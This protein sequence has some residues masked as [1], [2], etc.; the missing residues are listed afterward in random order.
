[1][2]TVTGYKVRENSEGKSFVVLE[3]SS[4]LQLVQSAETGKFYAA[5]RKCTVS[6]SF[7][8]EQAKMYVGERLP[9]RIERVEVEEYEYAN[10]KTGEVQTYTHGYA[11]NPEEEPQRVLKGKLAAA[12]VG[13]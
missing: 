1:M 8:E 10:E 12:I 5:V 7:T 3:L 11:Y 2:V 13:G 9:G 6:S 4:D